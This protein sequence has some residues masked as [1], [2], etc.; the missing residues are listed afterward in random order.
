VVPD[1]LC[2]WSD[3]TIGGYCCELFVGDLEIGNL[4]NP[5]GHSTE[6][7]FGWERLHQVIEGTTRVDETSLFDKRLSPIISDHTRTI[8]VMWKSGIGPGNKGRHYVCRRLI[9]RLLRLE[10]E[11][12]QFP[13]RDWF[14]QEQELRDKCVR[15]GRRMWRRHKEKPLEFW[16]ETFGIL[17]EE[18]C[19]LE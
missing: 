1:D 15:H 6:V 17:P 11:P 10:F 14:V 16:W 7:G 13:F 3:G 12:S 9:R 19:L 2:E 18:I 4:V 8:S 5:L